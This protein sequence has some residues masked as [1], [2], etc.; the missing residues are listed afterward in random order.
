MRGSDL[1]INTVSSALRWSRTSLICGRQIRSERHRTAAGNSRTKRNANTGRC[2]TC[3]GFARKL[4][5]RQLW[6]KGDE[7]DYC[8]CCEVSSL[9]MWKHYKTGE[10][11]GSLVQTDNIKKSSYAAVVTTCSMLENLKLN[12]GGSALHAANTHTQ[13]T[14]RVASSTIYS[15]TACTRTRQ[16]FLIA[17]SYFCKHHTAAGQSRFLKPPVAQ[18]DAFHVCLSAWRGFPHVHTDMRGRALI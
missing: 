15:N 14:K 10:D 13:F 16:V 17:R 1:H 3:E 4:N 18:T 7:E 11:R 12:K 6:L 2:V 8:T 5:L 9:W